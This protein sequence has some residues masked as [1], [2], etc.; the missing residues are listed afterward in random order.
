MRQQHIVID[1]AVCGG[2]LI[3]AGTRM[4]VSD[5]LD[6]L[7]SGAS[8]EELLANFPHLSQEDVLA[9]LP[10]LWRAGG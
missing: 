9:C 1:L 5:V 3:V 2:R 7:A 8:V 10:R 4:R 6:A